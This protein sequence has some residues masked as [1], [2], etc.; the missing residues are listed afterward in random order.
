MYMYLVIEEDR[1]LLLRVETK[2]TSK[3]VTNY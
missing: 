3:D 2:N 1:G